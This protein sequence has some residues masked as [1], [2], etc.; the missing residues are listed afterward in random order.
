MREIKFRLWVPMISKMT[1]PLSITDW[2]NGKQ[3][4]TVSDNCVWQ[5]YTGLKDKNGKEIYEG[6]VVK[7]G[8]S[9]TISQIIFED[10]SFAVSVNSKVCL[11]HHGM[12]VFEIIGNIYENAELVK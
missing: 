10:G 6:D 9:Q 12:E 8:S 2:A 5:Q 3:Q 4:I 11:R 7:A 1:Y